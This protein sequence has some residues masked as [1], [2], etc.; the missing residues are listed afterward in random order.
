MSDFSEWSTSALHTL[1]AMTGQ[2]MDY[3]EVSAT[4]IEIEHSLQSV[5]TVPVSI[6]KLNIYSLKQRTTMFFIYIFLSTPFVIPNIY[7]I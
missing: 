5:I 1:M 3:P 4:T 7:H 6:N 2:H